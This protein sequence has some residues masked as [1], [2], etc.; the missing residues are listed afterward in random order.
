MASKL[1]RSIRGKVAEFVAEQISLDVL[2]DWLVPIIWGIEDRRDSGAQELVYTI[3]L[4]IAEY[5]A[6]HLL[7]CDFRAQMEMLVTYDSRLTTT[8]NDSVFIGRQPS[9]AEDNLSEVE[10]ASSSRG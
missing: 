2:H 4:A 5:S 1:E 8:C 3:E 10:F 6:G 9:F 7:E